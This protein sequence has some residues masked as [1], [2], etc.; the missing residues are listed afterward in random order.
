MKIWCIFIFSVANYSQNSHL[1]VEDLQI[2]GK[3]SPIIPHYALQ[4]TMPK[5]I[6]TVSYQCQ[7][8]PEN[9]EVA[10]RWVRFMEWNG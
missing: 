10:G 6:H 9:K 2:C 8:L 1:P 4:H 3:Y 5:L 7:L